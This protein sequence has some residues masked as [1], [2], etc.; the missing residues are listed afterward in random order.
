MQMGTCQRVKL[1][2]ATSSLSLLPWKDLAKLCV[3][4]MYSCHLTVLSQRYD[5]VQVFSES[6]EGSGGAHVRA[7]WHHT[8]CLSESWHYSDAYGVLLYGASCINEVT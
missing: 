5:V 6:R 7:R 4:G 2:R 3:C 1:G 8:E